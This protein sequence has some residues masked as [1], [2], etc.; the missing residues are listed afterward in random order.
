MIENNKF[1]RRIQN[2]SF[3]GLPHE[4]NEFR[5][6]VCLKPIVLEILYKNDLQNK[7]IMISEYKYYAER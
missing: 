2:S 7:K 5:F 6:L 3:E 4:Q 1:W